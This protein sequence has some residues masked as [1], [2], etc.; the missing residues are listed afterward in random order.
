M[1][2][3]SLSLL[4]AFSSCVHGKENSFTG[5][6]PAGPV[7][8]NFLGISLTDSIDFIR[9]NFIFEDNKYSLTCNYG[10]GKPSTNGFING[11]KIVKLKGEFTRN[12]NYLQLVNEGK[13]LNLA[14]LNQNLLHIADNNKNLLIGTGG[15]S[16][17]LNNLAASESDQF[18]LSPLPIVLKDSMSFHGRTPCQGIDSRRECQKLKWSV[19]FYAD[20]KTNQ[21]TTYR[22]KGTTFEHH[23]PG[24]EQNGPRTGPW[25]INKGKDGRI[26]YQ[27][28]F[29]D[30]RR[31]LYLLKLDDN[32]VIFTDE[33][34]NLLVGDLDFSY[35]LSRKL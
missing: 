23:D 6:T 17:T 12:K 5:S 4:I 31:P 19:V 9:W 34:G 2:I 1:K 13:K 8:R 11:G 27:L 28:D 30:K 10:I 16:Y 7:V 18:S 22:I 35:S 29:Y 32:N 21:P 15:W 14:E 3:I 20:P 33:K 24:T 25:K 26:I